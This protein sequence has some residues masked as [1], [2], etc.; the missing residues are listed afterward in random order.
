MAREGMA[1]EYPLEISDELIY[2]NNPVNIMVMDARNHAISLKDLD[3]VH[4]SIGLKMFAYHYYVT[5]TGIIYGGRPER[6][7]NPDLTKLTK[8]LYTS[9]ISLNQSPFEGI[10]N[11][12][13]KDRTSSIS[14]NKIL[15]CLEGNTSYKDIPKAQKTSLI[16]L[17]KDIMSR[18]R[19]I[20]NVYS[21]REYLPMYENLGDMVDFASIRSE[22]TT[23]IPPLFVTT[24]AGTVTYS[25]GKRVL[26]YIEDNPMSGND[27]KLLEIY[28]K[29]L[30]IDVI[31]PNGKYDVFTVDAVRRFQKRYNLEITGSFK[32]NDFDVLN[33][34]IN[35]V[36]FKNVVSDSY[37]RLLYYREDQELYGKDIENLN[38]RLMKI[39]P[40]LKLNNYYS[41]DAENAVKR[42]QEF[43]KLSVDGIVG[44]IT[45]EKIFSY[46]F[47]DLTD[48]IFY[49]PSDN[50]FKLVIKMIQNKIK[51]NL[52]KFGITE[53]SM[54]GIYDEITYKNI[55]K[56]KSLIGFNISGNIDRETYEFFVD[57]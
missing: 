21:M 5:L 24:P 55:K 48:I 38:N 37:Y 35:K 50:E 16:T 43:T 54:H 39:F 17:C 46:E 25:F 7:L 52:N 20:K 22:A 47:T 45:W 27:V 30:G 32:K 12:E 31:Q 29:K 9:M 41:E 15:I 18:N 40:K 34:E 44:P 23:S 1:Y 51:N 6:A 57:L 10:D 53:Y 8:A 28:L 11:I 13:M 3:Q 2:T 14:S 49:D 4:R 36:K 56:I 33:T 26:R 42:F 19:N